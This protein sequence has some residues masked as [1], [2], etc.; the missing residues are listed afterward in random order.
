[1]GL[2]AEG[3]GLPDSGKRVSRLNPPPEWIIK[4][5]PQLRIVEDELWNQV[6]SRQLAIRKLT[7]NGKQ[8][9]FKRARRPKFL[10]SGLAKC[11][12][13]GGGYVM[14]WRNRLAC[15][16]ARSR[17]TCTNRRTISRQEIESRV[18]IAL[19]DKLM[20]RDLFE[21]FC[22]EY[23]KE[24]NRLRMEHRAKVSQ[25]RQELAV[26]ERQIRKLVQ[27]IKDADDGEVTALVSEEAHG[28][29]F[30]AICGSYQCKRLPRA[31]GCQPRTA[32][33]PECPH[34]SAVGRRPAGHC[35]KPL[36]LSLRRISSTGIRVPRITGFPSMTSGSISMRSVRSSRP[37]QQDKPK[38]AEAVA[39]RPK[40]RCGAP[41]TQQSS[42]LCPHRRVR[43]APD[44]VGPGGLRVQDDLVIQRLN[45]FA[46]QH[47]SL[48]IGQAERLGQDL[49][50][51][52][53]QEGTTV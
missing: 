46:R 52:H 47:G 13:C 38:P 2:P 12:V 21:E 11:T 4:D 36:Q 9:H 50:G 18:L 49:F 20:R 51:T 10:F 37:F 7:D 16:N 22:R 14:Y 35:P 5:V 42:R 1:L 41:H 15:F 39:Q 44:L 6:K 23:V 30:A 28:L 33:R 19:R 48:I 29:A 25:G 43:V 3:R 27:A 53:E 24:L 26:V 45:Q 32:W 31:R 34:A 40:P 17:G 8:V